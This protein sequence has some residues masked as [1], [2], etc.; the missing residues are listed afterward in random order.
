MI[1]N[2]DF[3]HGSLKNSTSQYHQHVCNTRGNTKLDLFYSNVKD[4]FTSSP[5]PQLG[6]SDH[7]L[8]LLSPKYRPIVQRQRPQS[9]AI[10]QWTEDAVQEIQASFECTDWHMFVDNMKQIRIPDLNTLTETVGSYINFCVE[11]I[12]PEKTV[13]VYP[14][15]KPWITKA[16]KDVI[17]GDNWMLLAHRP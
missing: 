7:N 2:G 6:K 17:R 15:N 10:E 5:L 9:L 16:V 1:I 12:V 4:A 11:T 3:N 14:N 8:V 13:K